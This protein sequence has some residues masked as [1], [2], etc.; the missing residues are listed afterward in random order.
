MRF[1]QMPSF[2]SY[3]AL[4]T[5]LLLGTGSGGAG[6]QTADWDGPLAGAGAAESLC[7]LYGRLLLRSANPT[8]IS[9]AGVGYFLHYSS[10]QRTLCQ[11]KWQFVTDCGSH[12]MSLSALIWPSPEHIAICLPSK[13]FA[14]FLPFPRMYIKRWLFPLIASLSNVY[15]THLPISKL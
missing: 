10:I 7:L 15:K 1:A 9:G 6:E 2:L 13:D 12:W 3:C 11:H 14:G 4:S 8:P 5:E